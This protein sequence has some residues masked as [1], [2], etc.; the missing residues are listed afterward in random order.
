MKHTSDHAH[1]HV[2]KTPVNTI[3]VWVYEKNMHLNDC[4]AS[5]CYIAFPSSWGDKTYVLIEVYGFTICSSKS[6]Q[7]YATT[8]EKFQKDNFLK[9][10]KY[11]M[12]ECVQA[13][14][15]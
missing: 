12:A 8:S 9:N 7:R 13:C 3:F 14:D 15:W 6:F 11:S 10:V 2:K 5:M 1:L 4:I